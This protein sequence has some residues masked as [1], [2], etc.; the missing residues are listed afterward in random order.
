VL[1]V[2]KKDENLRMCIDYRA[3][4]KITVRNKYS[5]LKID[6]LLDTLQS[7]R[8]FTTLDLDMTYRQIKV[9]EKDIAKTA[10]MCIESHYE[11]LVMTFGLTNALATFQEIMNKVF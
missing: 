8:F 11:F 3:L 9:K 5:L 7:T 1:F 2:R 10:F 6:E 4:N